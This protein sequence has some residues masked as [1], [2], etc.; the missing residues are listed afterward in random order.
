L[1]CQS[2]QLLLQGAAANQGELGA[3]SPLASSMGDGGE[4]PQGVGDALLLDEAPYEQHACGLAR[5]ETALLERE[6][7]EVDAVAMDDGPLGCAAGRQQPLL[8]VH[9]YGQ[10]Q[11]SAREHA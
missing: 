7:L 3:A 8:Q 5:L 11:R 9:A 4:R 2:P 10:G 6:A 1:G